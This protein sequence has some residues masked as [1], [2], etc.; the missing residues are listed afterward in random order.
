MTDN[1]GITE[2]LVQQCRFR[3]VRENTI[4]KVI[5]DITHMKCIGGDSYL[6]WSSVTSKFYVGDDY[7]SHFGNR[8]EHVVPIPKVIDTVDTAIAIVN[9][10][11][12]T[13]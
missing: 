11:S 4:T 13:V 1:V 9:A 12:I 10:L 7:K 2:I 6:Y 3:A 5:K 8:V